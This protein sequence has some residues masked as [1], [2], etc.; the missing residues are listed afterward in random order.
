MKQVQSTVT[1]TISIL[2]GFSAGDEGTGIA[3]MV[4]DGAWRAA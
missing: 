4:E 2:G 3:G 1:S